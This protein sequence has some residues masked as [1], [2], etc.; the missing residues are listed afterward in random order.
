MT[1]KLALLISQ[2]AIAET[3]TRLAQEIDHEYENRSPVVVGVLKGSF[4]F[5]AD[6]IRQMHTP[7]KRIELIKLSSYGSAKVSSGQVSVQMDL[8]C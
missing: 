3:V 4:I 5:L 8:S 7:I 1:D 2:Q 6:L